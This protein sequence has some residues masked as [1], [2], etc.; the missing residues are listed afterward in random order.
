MT[1]LFYVLTIFAIMY[2]MVRFTSPGR[3]NDFKERNKK[4][5][6]E[7]QETNYHVLVA[8]NFCYAIWAFIGLLSGLNWTW[9]LLLWLMSF[10]VGGSKNI[11]I[12][13]IDALLT[14]AL[15]FFI[16]L[17]QFHFQINIWEILKEIIKTK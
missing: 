17:N 15:L 12:M 2:E 13:K 9:F 11:V 10:T 3:I 4:L 16:L 5:D 14:V 7:D 1:H 6:H 8:L